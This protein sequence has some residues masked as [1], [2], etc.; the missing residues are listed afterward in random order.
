LD[1]S[2]EKTGVLL[3]G[4]YL[5]SLAVMVLEVT[6]T[7]LFSVVL[8]YH[9]VFIV[10]SFTILG[11]GT[12]AIAVHRLRPGSWSLGLS[13][14]HKGIVVFR[15][16]HTAASRMDRLSTPAGYPAS[17]RS[18]GVCSFLLCGNHPCRCLRQIPRDQR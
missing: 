2:K 15:V 18:R 3:A 6:L 7:R 12:G 8:Y 14:C 5:V 4:V 9:Y 11:L 1:G 13:V 16:F 10:V 17:L